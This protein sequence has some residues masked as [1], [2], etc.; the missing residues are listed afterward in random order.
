[1]PDQTAA[2]TDRRDPRILEWAR[3][4]AISPL[5]SLFVASLGRFDDALFD[6][7]ER[8]GPNQMHFLD[9]MRELRRRRDEIA[10]RFDEHLRR[11]WAALESGQP[12]SI[13]SVQTATADS[14]DLSL[15]SEQDL[16]SRLAAHNLASVIQREHKPVLARL[17]RRLAWIAG[18]SEL[19][20]QQNPIGPGHVGQ[21]VQE[22]FATCE[23][24]LEVRLVVV[25]LCERLLVPGMGRYYEEFDRRL[26]KAGVIPEMPA[27]QRRVSRAASM[28][29][30]AGEPEDADADAGGGYAEATAEEM[31][32]PMW[33]E[34]FHSRIAAF[35]DA[36]AEGSSTAVGAPPSAV[37][38]GNEAQDL[39]LQALHQL[40]QES[41]GSHAPVVEDVAQQR[42]MSQTEMMS[43]LSLLQSAPSATLR[44]A[45]GDT[46]ESLSQRLKNEVLNSASK[47]GMDTS[48]T[49]LAPL[50]E[51]AIDLV[52][53]LFDVMMDERDLE[54]RPRELIG[55]L[56]VPFVKVA[57]LDRRMFVQK[58]HPARRLLNALAEAC[59]GNSG[60]SAAERTLMAKVEEVVDRLVAE[61]NENLAIFMM[62]E[63]EFR[64]FLA[65]HRRR[66]EIAE[67]RATEIQR[68]Q[69]KLEAARARIDSEL[70]ARLDGRRLPGAIEEFLRQPWAHHAA[71]A[72]LREGEDGPTLAE[73]LA[74][75]DGVL[76]ELGEAQMQFVGKPWLQAWRP[77]LQKVF[78]SVGMNADAASTA[79]DALHDT[80]QAVAASRPD[81]EKRLPELPQVALPR[82]AQSEDST[83][84][85]LVGGTDL[86]D[87]FDS[88]DADHFRH[89]P[90]GTW[91]D[92]ID[93]DNKV[94]AGK[95][96]WVSPISSRLLFVNKRGVRFCV[97]S[98]EE[99]AVMVR[100]GRLRKHEDEDAFDAAMQGVIDRLDTGKAVA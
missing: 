59:E 24:M 57:L 72:V 10:S 11:A 73:S 26:E 2:V 69:E 33:A 79:I 35:R 5:T 83:V 90:L 68:G 34:R 4:G 12:L 9:G 70:G 3:E 21:A 15:V 95:L 58:T 92:F 29:A 16:E 87:E 25:K 41:R 71:M 37:V 51:D 81:L 60:E 47:I 19:D 39:L 13:D 54:G 1:M 6:R 64:D 80:L 65:Q 93:K 75:A 32:A 86:L 45:I 18:L 43:V 7:A 49:K 91:L 50:D 31:F 74:L 55:R 99:L 8:A 20:A 85:Q 77:Q 28:P 36:H 96:S 63:E 40:L 94:Q 48:A 56:V 82:P 78:A 53:M 84:I 17:D 89:L 22:A 27:A 76:Q 23:L 61:F 62:L 97:A 66:I 67:R 38:G 42:A 44:A 88:T 98:P 100:M 30:P 52:G 46:S 14:Q